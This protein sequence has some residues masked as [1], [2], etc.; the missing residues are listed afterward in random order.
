M[1]W[2]NTVGKMSSLSLRVLVARFFLHDLVVRFSLLRLSGYPTI[3]K[4][5]YRHSL[6]VYKNSLPIWPVTPVGVSP[7]V[8]VTGEIPL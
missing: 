2:K 8:V 7:D 6:M 1:T 5:L 4:S 3:V